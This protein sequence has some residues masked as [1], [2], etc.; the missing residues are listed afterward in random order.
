MLSPDMCEEF[1]SVYVKKIVDAVQDDTFT[2]VLH[3]CGNTVKL[4]ESM[5]GTGALCFHFGNAVDLVDILPQIPEDRIAM[6]NI[7]P[8]SIFKNGTV[9]EM[10]EKVKALLEKMKK[11]KNFVLSSGCDVPPNSP[12]ENVTAFYEALKEYNEKES[13]ASSER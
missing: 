8:V 5:I 10:K 2:V 1:S 7:D 3:N 13:P 12:I 9:M 6:G 4:I 11:Y